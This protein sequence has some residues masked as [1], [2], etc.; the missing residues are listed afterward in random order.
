MKRGEG[1][2][3]ILVYCGE[4]GEKMPFSTVELGS[5]LNYLFL[6]VPTDLKTTLGLGL[7]LSASDHF[8]L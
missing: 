5:R 1:R 2:K 7:I 3:G 6:W 4:R 8:S